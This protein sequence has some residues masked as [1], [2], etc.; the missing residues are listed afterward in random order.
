MS[1]EDPKDKEIR[2]MKESID[3]LNKDLEECFM[4]LITSIKEEFAH[5][6]EGILTALLQ[7]QDALLGKATE[8]DEEIKKEEP[9]PSRMFF[10]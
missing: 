2:E 10:I 6:G 5:M 4:T 7:I 1:E 9:K 3:R 8:L